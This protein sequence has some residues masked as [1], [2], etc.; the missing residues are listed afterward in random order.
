MS[1]LMSD[2][3]NIV[4]VGPRDGLQNE[5]NA[6]SLADKI[7]LVNQLSNTGLKHIEAGSFV[8]PRWVPQMADSAAVFKGIQ[9][10]NNVIYSALTPNLKGFE[11]A[12]EANADQVAIFAAVSESFSQKNINCSIAESIERFKPVIES[13]QNN[14]LKVRAYLSC[15]LGCPYEGSIKPVQVIKITEQ[16]LALGCYEV[17]LG[18]TIGIGTPYKTKAL[19]SDMLIEFNP[20]QLALH[21]HDT[22]GQALANQY[23]ALDLGLRTFDSS[24]AGLGGCPYATGA[25]GNVATEDFVYM[26]ENSGLKTGIDLNKLITAGQTVCKA[27]SR[28][29]NSKVSNALGPITLV[30]TDTLQGL[31]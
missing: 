7:L 4:E 13:A 25:S 19:L 6:I 24:I 14:N 8:S 30:N 12:L 15:I 3:V 5:K 10:S 1:G 21:F 26:L 16:L 31:I 11:A 27:L 18:D 2:Y 28:I 22:Y 17:S 23:V 9:R 20:A 29:N